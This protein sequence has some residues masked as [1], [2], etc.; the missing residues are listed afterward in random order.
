MI[1]LISNEL[2]KEAD[3][4]SKQIT[5]QKGFA[6]QKKDVLELKQKLKRL[7]RDHGAD[8]KECQE[9]GNYIESKLNKFIK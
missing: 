7:A 3:K 9:I 8:T 2:K 6:T 1:F 5:S 4:I